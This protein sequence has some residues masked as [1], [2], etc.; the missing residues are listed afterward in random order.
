MTTVTELFR[1]LEAQGVA[2][3]VLR[4]YEN[5][6]DL[7]VS[8]TGSN[9]DI[10][11]VVAS[12][13]LARF[14]EILTSIAKNLNWDA[15]S[16]C[17]HFTQ[18][19]SRHHNIEI[20]RFYRVEPLEFLQVDVFHGYL[21]WGLPLMDEADLL[22]G[23]RYDPQR[24]LTRVDPIKENIYRL[25]QVHALRGSARAADKIERY[26]RNV[27]AARDNHPVEFLASVRRCFGVFG[28]RAIRALEQN[29]AGVF[30]SAMHRAKAYF[31]LRFTLRHPLQTL[32][33]V[34]QRFLDNRA[35]LK[36]RQCGTLLKVRAESLEARERF[37]SMINSLTHALN[38]FDRRIGKP[39]QSG[40]T[41]SERHIM[42]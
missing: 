21:N 34:G 3:A 15:L 36:T 6:P 7:K 24:R 41:A 37:V 8:E 13:D 29:N 39:Q 20:F 2:Y 18:S 1:C 30:G 42:E 16:E 22:E 27:L 23:S 25:A 5:L 38:A 28:L 10:D 4:N 19:P 12:R 35:R 9:T 11:L 33:F 40:F 31:A 14:R 26:R 17:D 32:K